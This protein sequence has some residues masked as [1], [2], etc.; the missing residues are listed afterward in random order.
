MQVAPWK[1]L[2][3]VG[4]KWY[5]MTQF[6]TQKYVHSYINFEPQKIS[7]CLN[8]YMLNV[9]QDCE[10]EMFISSL[11]NPDSLSVKYNSMKH[12]IIPT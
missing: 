6:E 7:T 12:E 4:N 9:T 8:K 11:F 5:D 10:F 2:F 3:L 1:L